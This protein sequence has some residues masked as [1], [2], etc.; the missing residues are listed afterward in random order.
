V[1]AATVAVVMD[2]PGAASTPVAERGEVRQLAKPP[3]FHA[4]D[5]TQE[6]DGEDVEAKILASKNH[7][8]VRMVIT[9]PRLRTAPPNY[10]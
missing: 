4:V 5:E 8:S 6:V 3:L 2:K 10:H 9:R 1:V 7:H